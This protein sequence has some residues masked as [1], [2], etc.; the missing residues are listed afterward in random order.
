M[1]CSNI[2]WRSDL[3]ASLPEYSVWCQMID[4]YQTVGTVGIIFSM[5][6]SIYAIV[7]SSKQKQ[8]D[9]MSK[10]SEQLA[11][12]V[13]QDKQDITELKTQAISTEKKIDRILDQMEQP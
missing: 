5:G 7:R 13:L 2:Q 8:S 3:D 11:D 6:M 1:F 10:L 4:F 12:H 9:A